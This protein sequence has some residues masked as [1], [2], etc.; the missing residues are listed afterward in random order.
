VPSPF[1][2]ATAVPVASPA[3]ATTSPP[4]PSPTPRDFRQYALTAGKITFY[5]DRYEIGADDHVRVQLPDGGVVTGD[6]FAMNIKLNRFIVAGNVEI[7]DK[8]IDLHAAAFSRFLSPAER[9]YIVP[10]L[11]EPDRWTY[12]G[13]DLTTP[14]K[15]REM[16][17]D[18]FFLPDLTKATPFIVGKKALIV[19]NESLKITPGTVVLGPAK[20]PT[21]VYFVNLSE[22]VNYSQNSLAA[23]E[24]DGPYPFA[25]GTR[26]RSTLHV[27]YDPL[28]KL[29]LSYEQQLAVTDHSYITGSI[30][31]MTRPQRQYNLIGYD[32]LAPQLDGRL[33]LQESAFQQWLNQPLSASA[34]IAAQ[35]TRGL[36]HLGYLQYNQNF[37][38]ESLLSAPAPVDGNQ[39]FY[40]DP[41]H[42]WAPG[43]PSDGTLTFNGFD[44]K[45]YYT[46]NNAPHWLPVTYRLRAGIGYA[47]DP[48]I[49]EGYDVTPTTE[50]GGVL[51]PTIW[52][53]FVGLT[54]TSSS[55]RLI[56]DRK[57]P[58][59]SIMLNGFVDFQRQ[60]FSLP[61][62]V[63]T[64]QLS[65]S[66]S[67]TVNRYF[68]TYANY[69]LINIGDSYGSAQLAGYPPSAV[70]SPVTNHTYD[71][72]EA[73]IG[74]ATIRSWTEGVIY[75]ASP[76][77]QAS[78]V[79]RENHDF[80]APV[81]GPIV[82]LVGTTPY[83]ITPQIRA[84]ILPNLLVIVQRSYYFH[85]GIQNWDPQF[86]FQVTK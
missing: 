61:H 7:H 24:F 79:I 41:S 85:F 57:N 5:Y 78:L 71:G 49:A 66:V 56:K 54:L 27:R 28:N 10:I 22:N 29:Y 84:R 14:L 77:F 69:Q 65:V 50:Y 68:S 58:A 86:L 43:H 3:A 15:G 74:F 81:P 36:T 20:I 80:P 40:G 59:N 45:I 63:N 8:G 82:P 35:F 73:F 48:D 51:Y 62:Q 70:Y 32:R 18:T 46:V 11:T 60:G 30:N 52:H 4:L 9:T 1:A 47:N 13:D 83:Q 12:E 6:T 64:A 19:P 42:P 37:F 75:N 16:P 17:G 31:P 39:Y 76:A 23:A 21:P 67:K 34:V 26:A 55:F 25:G 44:Q 33:L 38:Y 2:S 53:N 72:Y